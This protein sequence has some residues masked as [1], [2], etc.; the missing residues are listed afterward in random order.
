MNHIDTS[1]FYGPHVTNQII[2]Q[3]LHPYP[4]GL[5]I[6]TKVGARRGTDKSW[7]HAL[8]RQE[9]IDGGSRQPSKPRPGQARCRQFAGRRIDGALGGID[10]GTP[11]GAR[12]TQASGIDPSSRPEQCQPRQLSE[13]QKISE[14]VCV[15]N[16]YNI[17]HRDDDGFIDELARQGMAYV[18]FFPL[19]GF[20]PLQSAALDRAAASLQATPM[21]VALAWLLQR[22]PN[23]ADSRHIFR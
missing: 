1:D 3:A 12:R 13:A 4:D 6:V 16:F 2:K 23:S 5:V 18:P 10:R 22:A 19:G 21:Q 8:S 11:Y 17:A 14:I 15:Q 20:T 9:L 7:I